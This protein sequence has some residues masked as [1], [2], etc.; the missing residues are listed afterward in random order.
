LDFLRRRKLTRGE[1]TKY[2]IEERTEVL[3][4]SRLL[5]VRYLTVAYD[6]EDFCTKFGEDVRVAGERVHGRRECRHGRIASVDLT[7]S[8]SPGL[9][10]GYV[11]SEE[12]LR[13]TLRLVRLFRLMTATHIE[14][15][16]LE[17]LGVPSLADEV[18]KERPGVVSLLR[19]GSTLG[20]RERDEAI[21]HRADF[22]SIERASEWTQ[23]E[24]EGTNGHWCRVLVGED[25]VHGPQVSK[26]SSV[27]DVVLHGIECVY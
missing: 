23:G 5:V 20:Q 27:V 22:L 8:V 12:N 3:H 16:I 24:E 7:V 18:V 14:D 13:W 2:L 19:D 9:A 4:T 15:L 6:G 10:V 17:Y 1:Q 11:R 21:D 26:L 25:L